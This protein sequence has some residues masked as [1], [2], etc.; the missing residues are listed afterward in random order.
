MIERTYVPVSLEVTKYSD[1][2]VI[3]S[4]ICLIC[5]FSPLYAWYYP[6][7]TL[8]NVESLDDI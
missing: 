5:S 4:C 1:S 2:L 8:Q 6:I 3:M 7:G